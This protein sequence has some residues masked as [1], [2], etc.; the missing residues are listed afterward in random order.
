MSLPVQTDRRS[1]RTDKKRRTAGGRL[2]DALQKTNDRL[3][4]PCSSLLLQ[5]HREDEEDDDGAAVSARLR[6]GG[7]Q[8]GR[9]Q[10]P[11]S[12]LVKETDSPHDQGPG[13]APV[14]GDERLRSSRLSV[15]D[16]KTLV[17]LQ[18]DGFR[19]GRTFLTRQRHPADKH[20]PDRLSSVQGPFSFIDIM[21]D[22]MVYDVTNP[23][24]LRSRLRWFGGGL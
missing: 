18:A 10:E 8:E 14:Q 7:L 21:S 12:L 24:P 6:A 15:L 3:V 4:I 2:R 13:S 23:G 22:V 1:R 16:T 20:Q 19:S 5:L 9:D 11:E 17:R